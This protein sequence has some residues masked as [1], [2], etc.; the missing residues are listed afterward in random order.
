[1]LY[2]LTANISSTQ[3][4]LLTCMIII[5]LSLIYFLLKKLNQNKK[6]INQYK[7]ENQD[8][9]KTVRKASTQHLKLQI[10]WE[11]NKKQNQALEKANEKIKQASKLKEIFLANT[12]HEMRT[13]LNAIIGYTNLLFT[14]NLTQRQMDYLNHIKNS[15]DNLL[16]IINDI[17]D[18]SKIEAGKFAIEKR[19]F[20]LQE[21]VQKILIALKSK[22]QQKHITL[23]HKIAADIPQ[24]LIGDDTRLHQILSNLIGNAIKFTGTGGK[25]ELTAEIHQKIENRCEILFKVKDNGIGIAKKDFNKIFENFS[26]IQEQFNRNFGGT[27]LGLAIVK[28]LIDIQEGQIFIDSKIGKGTTFSFII[29]YKQSKNNQNQTKTQKEIPIS[30]LDEIKILL[31]DDNDINLS[32]VIDTLSSFNKHLKFDKACNGNEAVKKVKENNYDLIIMDIQMPEM[33]GIEATKHIRKLSDEKAEIPIIGL[34][35]HA[36]KEE[37]KECLKAGLNDYLTKPFNPKQLI[38]K[39]AL[40]TEKISDNE[41]IS[42]I[43]SDNKM[44]YNK[45]NLKHL[46]LTILIGMYEGNVEKAQRM[47]KLFNKNL[48]GQIQNLKDAYTNKKIQSVKTLAHSLKTSFRYLGVSEAQNIA[49]DIEINVFNEKFFEKKLPVHIQKIE[50]I[51]QEVT[52]EIEQSTEAIQ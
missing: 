43:Y 27:G 36:F 35:A 26:Q 22:A 23:S 29:P 45:L 10:A 46:N 9:I 13:P 34:S 17:L 11:K 15:G 50:E 44:P 6:I 12:S 24:H 30:I 41:F 2:F 37:K 28:K 16:I 51:W 3:A 33:D 21:L 38:N 14:T 49:F 48:P 7:T 42:V 32:L 8:L 40:I 31:V 52:D 19:S 39:I 4:I 47:L 20:S 5:C 18:I 1:M 25:I